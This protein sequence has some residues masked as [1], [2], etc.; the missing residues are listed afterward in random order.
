MISNGKNFVAANVFLAGGAEAFQLGMEEPGALTKL[1]EDFN[2]LERKHFPGFCCDLFSCCF[3]NGKNNY[4]A[5]MNVL[6]SDF[7]FKLERRCDKRKPEDR[8]DLLFSLGELGEMLRK[9]EEMVAK[10]LKNI[11]NP[12]RKQSTLTPLWKK[13]ILKFNVPA[14]GF[15]EEEVSMKKKLENLYR[16]HMKNWKELTDFF[17]RGFYIMQCFDEREEKTWFANVFARSR[18]GKKNGLE[19]KKDI[20]ERVLNRSFYR[21]D[22]DVKRTTE[23]YED[24]RKAEMRAIAEAVG[25]KTNLTLT[26]VSN[27]DSLDN[28]LDEVRAKNGSYQHFTLWTKKFGTSNRQL[29]EGVLLDLKEF[30]DFI[31]NAK[32]IKNGGYITSEPYVCWWDKTKT[33]KRIVLVLGRTKKK[34]KFLQEYD[35]RLLFAL[36][37]TKNRDDYHKCNHGCNY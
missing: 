8:V 28:C 30:F 13:W 3:E 10:A 19:S 18:F 32:I 11:P 36:G 27:Y 14:F 6:L 37:V 16:P 2:V 15:D 24:L 29:V 17:L 25:T 33:K 4:L 34:L 26:K 22:L 7:G 12:T 5:E 21:T 31:K 35:T 23:L 20:E 9:A 1:V